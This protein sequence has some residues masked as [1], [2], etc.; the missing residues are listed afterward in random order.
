[1]VDQPEIN[2]EKQGL[3]NYLFSEKEYLDGEEEKMAK[4]EGTVLKI[5]INLK[6]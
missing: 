5:L 6:I 2:G 4:Y 3:L 1:M